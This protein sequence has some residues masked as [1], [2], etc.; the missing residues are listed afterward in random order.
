MHKDLGAR[1]VPFGGW[2]MPVQ[3]SGII[4][5]TNAVRNS[6]G[7]FDISH[8]GRVHLQGDGATAMLQTLTTN[9]VEKLPPGRA[10]Y[11]LLTNESGGCI[12]DII[13]YR[14]GDE[15]YWV[16]INASNR[17]RD[18]SW[19]QAHL[20]SGVTFEDW[21]DRTAMIAVQG[22]SA[23]QLLSKSLDNPLEDLGRFSFTTG[24]FCGTPIT[25]CRT[26]YT[27][28]DGAEVILPPAI[29]ETFWRNLLAAGAVSCGLGARDTL[30]VEAGY[31]L[32]GHEIDDNLGPVEA[33]LMW[34]VDL[35][36]GPFTGRDA[37]L[38]RKEQGAARRLVGVL[39]PG[40]LS[41]RQGYTLLSG[42]ET[43]G[44]VT[45]GTFSP[46]RGCGIGM[47]Y[48][49]APH[50]AEGTELSMEV[51]GVRHPVQIVPKKSLLPARR[52]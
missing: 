14:A 23:L 21:S 16:V 52:A 31:P 10:H 2:E 41:P 13:V 46:T 44:E 43:V 3:Y 11:S 17:S 47:A 1:M 49:A 5:E 42:E 12:D 24:S 28:E 27:G 40:R 30:R 37:I 20:P 36:K 32:Y 39:A 19:F 9:N 8:M 26:G 45:S 7:L 38:R 15:E 29:A 22:P 48:V 6:V 35:G 33:M 51:R 4:D 50:H 18:I 34:V 25:I